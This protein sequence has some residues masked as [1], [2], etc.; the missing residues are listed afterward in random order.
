[1][2]ELGI[3]AKTRRAHTPITEAAIWAAE[4]LCLEQNRDAI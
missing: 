2:K 3:E 1:L 4:S